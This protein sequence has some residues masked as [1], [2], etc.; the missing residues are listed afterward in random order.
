MSDYDF[1]TLNDKDFEELV[2]DLLS[3]EFGNRIERFK[4]GKDGGVDGRFFSIDGKEEIIQCKHWIKSGVSALIQSLSK[5]ELAKVHK[6]KPQKY[7][8]ITSLSLSRDNKIKIK[9]IFKDYIKID[10]QI[11]GKEDLN[12]LLK[13]HSNVERNHYKL[14]ISSTTVL[15]TIIHADIIGTSRYKLDEINSKS[16]KYVVTENH[17]EA[18][19]ILEEKGSLI[20]SGLPGIGKTTL[21]DQICRSYLAQGFDFYY[22]EDS[23]SS[24]EKVYKEEKSQIFYFDDFL[25]SNYLEAIENKEDSK[26]SAFIRRVEKIRTKDLY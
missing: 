18:I 5:T 3:A 17:S 6:L 4:S 16:I 24:I 1:S 10:N 12:D 19:N 21:A 23:I 8:L 26:I 25:G 14:W 11:L 15:E 22:I 20:I 2:V 9:N 13:K 7:F